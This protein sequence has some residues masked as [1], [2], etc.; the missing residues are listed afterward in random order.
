MLKGEAH[1][2]TM[3]HDYRTPSTIEKGKEAKNP[4]VPLQIKRTMGETMTCIP[5]VAFNKSSHNP[6]TRAAQNYSVVEYLSQTPCVVSAL[7]VLQS[8]PL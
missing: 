7:E 5:K 8:Y 2:A 6:N 4:S 3:E 1:I